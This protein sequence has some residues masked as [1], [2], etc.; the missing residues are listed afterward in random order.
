MEVNENKENRRRYSRNIMLEGI[1]PEGQQK[2]CSSSVLFIGCGALGTVASMYLAA[3]GVG[4]IG[5][6]DFDTVD[7]SNLQRQLAFST[8]DIGKK[9]V[10][11]L[12]GKLKMINPKVTVE[13]YDVF[14][15]KKEVE[16]IISGYDVIVEGSDNPDTKYMVSDYC[17]KMAM[18]YTMGAISEY[19]GQ[20][21]T[22]TPGS[23][24]YRDFFAEPAGT[25]DFTPCALGGVL[26][27]LPG[28]VGSIQAAEVIKLITGVDGLLTDC[29][30]LVDAKNMTFTT[31]RIS[32]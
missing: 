32:K 8:D 20:V 17:V 19:T 29:I 6:V 22:Y 9:K 12:S 18:P 13:K 24:S 14:L 30:L 11:V 10:E 21:M 5:L 16:N 27:P 26:G 25:G 2:L 15:A 4:R 28:I 23:S 31:F 3:S 1:G 7:V